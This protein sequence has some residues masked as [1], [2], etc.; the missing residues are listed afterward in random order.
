MAGGRNAGHGGTQSKRLMAAAD[1]EAAA[2]LDAKKR[3]L[4]KERELASEEAKLIA[5][6][7]KLE[8][9]K[10]KAAA[11]YYH[12]GSGGNDGLGARPRSKGATPPGSHSRGT[13]RISASAPKG[14]GTAAGKENT[15]PQ[16]EPEEQYPGWRAD[17]GDEHAPQDL[18]D[19]AVPF[20][21]PTEDDEDRLFGSE[22]EK[23]GSGTDDER[24]EERF[25]MGIKRRGPRLEPEQP[26]A[27][28]IRGQFLSR[29]LSNQAVYPSFI[30]RLRGEL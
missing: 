20:V 21:N 18:D 19:R 2:A 3:R 8:F 23:G 25:M 4:A 12:E 16:G 5:A 10:D 14:R 15:P 27:L 1:K 7:K 6:K 30:E 29:I 26:L 17:R 22:G 9:E 11:T 24:E 28:A 13:A